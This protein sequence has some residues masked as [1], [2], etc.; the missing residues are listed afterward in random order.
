MALRWETGDGMWSNGVRLGL[1]RFS[2]IGLP[3]FPARRNESPA[4]ARAGARLHRGAKKA[5]PEPGFQSMGR[6]PT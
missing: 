3:R 6:G 4:V 5:R 1:S 2:P